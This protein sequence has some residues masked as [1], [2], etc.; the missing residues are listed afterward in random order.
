MSNQTK[1]PS[2]AGTKTSAEIEKL[3]DL[4][5]LNRVADDAAEQAGKTEQHYDQDH[6]IFTK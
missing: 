6:G 4:K 2:P 3:E 5:K 1:T